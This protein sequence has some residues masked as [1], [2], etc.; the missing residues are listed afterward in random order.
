MR[1][2]WQRLERQVASLLLRA[3]PE[4]QR[5]ELVASKRLYVFG[6]LCHLQLVYQ[7]GGLA[8]KQTL[9]RNLEDPP[10]ASSLGEAVQTLRRWMRWRQRARELQ[11]SEPDPTV[12]IRAL[13]R[14]TGKVLDN[15]KELNFRLALA[16]S[17]LLVDTAPTREVVNQF[18]THLFA[19]MEQVSHMEK[20]SGGKSA[21]ADVPKVKKLEEDLKTAER[22]TEK[23]IKEIKR[24]EEKPSSKTPCR[25]YMTDQGC[26]KGKSCTWP[27]VLDEALGTKKRCWTCGSTRHF[28]T[29]CPTTSSATTSSTSS[30]TTEANGNAKVKTVKEELGVASMATDTKPKSVGE[31]EQMK[32]LIDKANKM[33]KGLHRRMEGLKEEPRATLDDLQRQLDALKSRNP[34]IRVLRLTKMN[35]ATDDQ[36]ALLDSGATHPMRSLDINDKVNELQRVWVSLADGNKVP[37][38]MSSGGVMI[39]TD[40]TV[41]PIIPLGWLA[42]VGCRISWTKGGLEVRHPTRGLLPVTILPGCPQVPRYL[43]LEL[44]KEFED[45]REEYLM[46]T[47]K[48][49]KKRIE[50]GQVLQWLEEVVTTHPVLNRLPQRIKDRLPVEPGEWSNLPVNRHRRKRLKQ[51]F[52]LH[53]FAGEQEGYTLEKAMHERK[54][55]SRLLEID[56]KRGP[57]HDL[58]APGD[59]TYAAILRAAVDGTILA[60]VGGPN[61]RTR[62]VLRHYPDGPRP[63]RAWDGE[64]YGLKNLTEKEQQMVE[65]DDLL[66]WRFLFVAIVADLSRK[67]RGEEHGCAVALEQPSEPDYMPE[68]VSWWRTSEW[69]TLKRLNGWHEQHFNQGDYSEVPKEVPVKPTTIGGSLRLQLPESRNPL[70]KGRDPN[71]PKDSQML[72]RWVPD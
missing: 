53:L 17:Q 60:V 50:N 45:N 62:S 25:F 10:E 41:E 6:I 7:P 12:L 61:C 72:S 23:K 34:S 47:I 44:I 63:V 31:E 56:V 48:L 52:A 28:S 59:Q 29:A 35:A 55:S 30:G 33:L 26:R 58:L 68:T 70:A 3:I 8:E 20:K 43:A 32:H 1:K 5:E 13:T 21:K 27:H 42:E 39:S 40:F 2:Q 22:S 24:E 64:E 69:K 57:D 46:K 36:L 71:G 51:G 37:M 67:A 19:E 9:I 11:T 14:I 18:T 66:M 54:L 65:D 16:R 38:L 4:Q 15:N 49:E